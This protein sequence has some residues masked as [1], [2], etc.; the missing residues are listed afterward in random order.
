MDNEA[1]QPSSSETIWKPGQTYAMAVVCLVIGLAIGYLLRGSAAPTPSA[2]VT[3][4]VAG[5]STG[6]PHAGMGQQPMPTLEDMKRMAD[7]QAAPLLTTLKTDPKNA[8]L[9]NKTALTYKAAHQFKDAITY[10][11][12][13]LDID[14]KNVA[15]R[16]D[17]A[18]CM[19]Y[20][21]DVDGALDQLTKSLTY[22]PKFPGTLMNIGI[23]K[24]QGKND[25]KGAIASWET[26]L[27][28]NP[29]F[30]QK[31]MIEHLITQAQQPQNTAPS[32]DPPKG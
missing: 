5:Q 2:T 1:D 18:S 11:Q 17:M 27:K 12:K 25:V 30:P 6:D 29:D 26:L 24:W 22:D 14:P 10:F 19:Y 21:G 13:A 9:L 8:A 15:I 28:L 32:S 20:S 16:D 4:A 3:A 31:E 7:K 23:I